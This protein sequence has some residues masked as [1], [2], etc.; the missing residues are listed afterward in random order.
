M[1]V[2]FMPQKYLFYRMLFS[3]QFGIRIAVYIEKNQQQ[4]KTLFI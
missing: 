1:A 2:Q 4:Q 3:F